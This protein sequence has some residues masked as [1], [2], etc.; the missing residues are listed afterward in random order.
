[1]RHNIFVSLAA[2][3]IALCTVCGAEALS[4]AERLNFSRAFELAAAG[5]PEQL[6]QAVSEGVNFNV[7]KYLIFDEDDNLVLNDL[8]Y[9]ID[10]E[11]DSSTP[12]HA[13]AARNRNPESIRFLISLSL[14][15]NAIA[16]AGNTIDETPLTCAIRNKNN[17]QVITELLNAGAAPDAWNS[18]DNYSVFH[19]V[20]S[21]CRDY[22]YAK[23]VID[24]LIRAGGNVNAHY[25]FTREEIKDLYKNKTP[26]DFRIIWSRSN[27][28]GDAI[29]GLSH[30]ARGNF[31]SSF[32]PLMYAVLFNNP[33]A[34]NILLDSGADPNI[35]SLEGKTALDYAKMQP[36]TTK[37][38]RSDAFIRLQK[39][40][41]QT[42]TPQ[43]RK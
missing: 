15:V 42:K 22:S 43:T 32:T 17:I 40:S 24:A 14:D 25:K 26:S 41:R 20:A 9:D 30:A 39:V 35:R 36:K 12:L 23:A 3:I 7:E 13:A 33:D 38:R 34:V 1:M 6:R 31:L 37:L 10:Y 28:F 11:F 18:G 29:Y 16:A 27:P 2:A 5:T 21:E 19:L 4:L 8:D